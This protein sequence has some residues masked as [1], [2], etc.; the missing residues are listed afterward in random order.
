[1]WWGKGGEGEGERKRRR[2]DG[3]RKDGGARGRKDSR[4]KGEIDARCEM[5]KVFVFLRIR[6]RRSKKKTIQKERKKDPKKY[7]SRVFLSFLVCFFRRRFRNSRGMSG[8]VW[9]REGKE[10]EEMDGETRQEMDGRTEEANEHATGRRFTRFACKKKG[11]RGES[12]QRVD[13]RP[14]SFSFTSESE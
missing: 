2:R 6:I 4:R 11:R 14:V 12:R 1:M 7:H 10:E 9:W 13:S 5:E 8:C 3:E